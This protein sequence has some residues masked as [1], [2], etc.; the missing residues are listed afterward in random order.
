[1][2][3][4]LY[5]SIALVGYLVG[6]FP[7]GYLVARARGIDIRSRGSGNIGATNVLRLFGRTTGIAV[8]L[9]DF[10]KGFLACYTLPRVWM[11]FG[12]GGGSGSASLEVAQIVAGLASILGHNYTVWLRF[13]G[14]KGIATSAGVLIGLIPLSLVVLLGIWAIVFAISRYVSLASMAAA[15][16]LPFVGWLLNRNQPILWVTIIIAVLAI[17]R[18]RSNLQRLW[19]GTEPKVGQNKATSAKTSSQ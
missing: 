7:T 4:I 2:T 17:Y 10:A 18:H 19:H 13:K 3:V 6:S 15:V 1:M 12:W 11:G 8:L 14:G 5:V 9:F 16:S